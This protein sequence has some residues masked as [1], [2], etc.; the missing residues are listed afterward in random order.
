MSAEERARHDTERDALRSQVH[1]ARTRVEQRSTE[2]ACTQSESDA[3]SRSRVN[4]ANAREAR[5]SAERAPHAHG[6]AASGLNR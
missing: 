6:R 5:L 3:T 2:L 1:S 4:D